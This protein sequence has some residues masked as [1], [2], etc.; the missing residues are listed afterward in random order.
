MWLWVCGVSMGLPA[1]QQAEEENE[2]VG[3]GACVGGEAW[4]VG[5]AA[6]LCLVCCL[7][8]NEVFEAV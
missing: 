4:A 6:F 5:S 2:G 8:T 7:V 1:A 3:A